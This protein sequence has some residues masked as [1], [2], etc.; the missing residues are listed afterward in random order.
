MGPNGGQAPRLVYRVH[1]SREVNT[2]ANFGSPI[3]K[4]ES[5]SEG[6]QQVKLADITIQDPF[7]REGNAMHAEAG[8][9]RKQRIAETP[10]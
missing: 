3:R 6:G 9:S 7:L 5:N 4:A 10:R 1:A 2:E 8:F